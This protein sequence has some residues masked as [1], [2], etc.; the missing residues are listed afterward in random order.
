MLEKALFSG[1]ARENASHNNLPGTHM[2]SQS[3]D[4]RAIGEVICLSC[5]ASIS[6]KVKVDMNVIQCQNSACNQNK[7]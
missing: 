4:K 6:W 3:P 2:E 1:V 7:S 5:E